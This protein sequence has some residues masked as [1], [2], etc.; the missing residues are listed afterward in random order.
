MKAIEAQFAITEQSNFDRLVSIIIDALSESSRR[1]YQHTYRLWQAFCTDNGYAATAPRFETVKAFIDTQDIAQATRLA[2]LSHIRRLAELVSVGN[3]QAA[4][5]YQA[6][7]GFLRVARGK[8]RKVTKALSSIEVAQAISAW[9]GD[10]DKAIRNRAILH[11]LYATG[12]RRSELVNI[13]RGDLDLNDSTDSTIAI[14]S[15][16]GDKPRTVKIATADAV[17]ALAE[18]TAAHDSD[19]VFA[20]LTRSR[21]PR[22]QG[23]AM[24]AQT[25]YEVCKASG[26]A[27]HEMRRTHI[28][29]A[30]E[31]GTPLA[32]MQAQAG[33]ANGATTLIYAQSAQAKARRIR[34]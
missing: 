17:H 9:Q 13:R 14:A 34:L 23:K 1:Q 8:D 32:D 24:N 12:I 10:S 7:K 20:A 3:P 21:S 22:F 16:K 4:A 31:N 33:H 25:V 2:R 26:F 28:T 15:G 18:L 30:L 19:F 5:H 29:R 27:P 11:T 6:I